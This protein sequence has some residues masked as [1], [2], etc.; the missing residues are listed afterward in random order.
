MDIDD[1]TRKLKIMLV[2][3]VTFVISAFVAYS[4]LQY[5]LRGKTTEATVDR[6]YDTT[7]RRGGVT[8]HVQ[9]HYHDAAGNLRN[10]SD[11]VADDFPE[12]AKK[13]QIE[14]LAD[15]SRV[16]GHRNIL[17]LT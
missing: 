10:S 13:V 15:T 12:N 3:I 4:E 1:E 7:G 6:V 8:R 14:Y 16:A 2:V 5:A 17:A 9:Y 11:T